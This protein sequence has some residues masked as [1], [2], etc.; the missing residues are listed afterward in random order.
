[1]PVTYPLGYPESHRYPNHKVVLTGEFRP[2]RKGE[3][4]ASGAIV[5]GYQAAN[6]L[7]TAFR[8]CRLVRVKMVEVIVPEASHGA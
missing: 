8:I 2:P 5:E 1:M 6:D 7:T 3:W 4:Y